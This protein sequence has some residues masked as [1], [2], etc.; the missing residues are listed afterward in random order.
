MN[1]EFDLFDSVDSDNLEEELKNHSFTWT[2]SLTWVLAALLIFTGGISSGIWFSNLSDES[3]ATNNNS[4]AQRGQQKNGASGEKNSIAQEGQGNKQGNPRGAGQGIRGKIKNINGMNLEVEAQDG[5]V[6]TVK[7]SDQTKVLNTS[8]DSFASLKVGDDISIVGPK[9]V[10]GSINPIAITIGEANTSSGAI[11]GSATTPNPKKQGGKG[12]SGKQG[13]QGQKVQPKNQG[14]ATSPNL[15]NQNPA[16][17]GPNKAGGPAGGGRF[18]SPE[19]QSCLQ[20]A[21]ITLTEGER[22]NMQD[23][24]VS[25]A[26]EKCRASL[27]LGK[28]RGNGGGNGGQS[29]QNS[30]N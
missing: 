11:N 17:N 18:N 24:Q 3:A 20:D 26:V 10:D 7:A 25:A 4:A 13:K 28:G 14:G 15:T 1:K 21:G 30:N 22:P 12:N 29:G 8:S 23:P 9:D 19:F 6:V 16:K 2:N 5:S 27:G